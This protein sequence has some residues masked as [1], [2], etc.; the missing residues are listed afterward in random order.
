MYKLHLPDGIQ[1]PPEWGVWIGEI[2]HNLR[3]GLDN[4]L[5]QLV[6]R[7]H[8]NRG[9]R[10]CQQARTAFPI[11]LYGPRTTKRGKDSQRFTRAKSI[12]LGKMIGLRNLARVKRCQPYHRRNGRWL[13][14]LWLLS[15]LNNADKHNLIITAGGFSSGTS[16]HPIIGD[17]VHLADSGVHHEPSAKADVEAARSKMDMY[18]ES[19][20]EITFG[21]GC[22]AVQDFPVIQTLTAIADE[23]SRTV[24]DFADQFP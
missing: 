20:H 22:D 11:Y 10:L 4:L 8:P 17:I 7:R 3:S 14:P 12:R 2:A 13:S 19:F 5:C 9:W 23:A 18:V 24:E 6:I 1:T 15:E 16:L 21:E